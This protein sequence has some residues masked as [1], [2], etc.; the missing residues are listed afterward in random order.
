MSETARALGLPGVIS[1]KG[2]ALTVSRITFK[3]EGLFEYW[4]ESQR[5]EALER[6]RL[7]GHRQLYLDRLKLAEG[8][9]A[10][11]AFSWQGEEAQKAAWEQPGFAELSYLCVV[12]H[13]PGWTRKEHAELLAAPGKLEELVGIIH[14]ISKPH[15]NGSAPGAEVPGAITSPPGNSSESS[16]ATPTASTLSASPD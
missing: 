3:V 6:C 7:R 11:H 15:P 1:W 16:S 12:E 14:R 2:R 9:D 10:R 13:Q 8:Q 4:L 5:D